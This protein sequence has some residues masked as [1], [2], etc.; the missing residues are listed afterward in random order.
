ME[1]VVL[2][3]EQ[4]EAELLRLESDRSRDERA[5]YEAFRHEMFIAE[6]QDSQSD[7]PRFVHGKW[8]YQLGHSCP[9]CDLLNA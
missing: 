8:A 7:I 4:E 5:R 1:Q 2:T 9:T 3:K 6:R